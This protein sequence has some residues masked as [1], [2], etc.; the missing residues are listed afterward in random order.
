MGVIIVL[1]EPS[2]IFFV[3]ATI[4][5]VYVIRREHVLCSTLP[6]ELFCRAK[7]YLGLN[8]VF[9]ASRTLT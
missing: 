4:F 6:T 1:F 9:Y 2:I 8:V 5:V 7:I 3:H